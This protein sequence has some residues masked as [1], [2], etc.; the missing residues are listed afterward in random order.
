[1]LDITKIQRLSLLKLILASVENNALSPLRYFVALGF[2]ADKL[3]KIGD[4]L[5]MLCQILFKPFTEPHLFH[6]CN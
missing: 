3:A 2:D 4:T 1:M 6:T 5:P